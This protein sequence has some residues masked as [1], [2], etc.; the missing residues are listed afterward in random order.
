VVNAST[1]K[2][3]DMETIRDVAENSRTVITVEGHSINQ[4]LG[5]AVSS[6]LDAVGYNGKRIKMGIDNYPRSDDWRVLFREAGIDSESIYREI[7]KSIY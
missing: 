6:A 5:D 3:L 7:M 4:G 1:L 2:P